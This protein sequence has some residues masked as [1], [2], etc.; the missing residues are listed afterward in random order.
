MVGPALGRRTNGTFSMGSRFRPLRP[1]TP[2]VLAL[3]ALLPL[4]ACGDLALGPAAGDVVM[5]A[6]V[7]GGAWSAGKLNAAAEASSGGVFAL[8]GAASDGRSIGIVLANIRGPGTY[9]LGVEPSVV[10]GVA[11]LAAGA[12][13]WATP[14]SGAAGS[15]TIDVLTPARIAGTFE[16]TGTLALG[17]SPTTTRRVTQ[18]TFDLELEAGGTLPGVPENAGSI[19]RMTLGGEPFNAASVVEEDL[20]GGIQFAAANLTHRV[21]VSL[22]GVA[23][24]GSYTL[25]LSAGRT[26]SVSGKVGGSADPYCCWGGAAAD[27]GMVTITSLTDARVRGTFSATLRP[28]P[29]SSQTQP[30]VLTSG[31]F[32]IGR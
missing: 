1:P 22:P 20:A 6:Q 17:S 2:L 13:V 31:T 3:P 7:D 25:D 32:D 24:T 27:A 28:V 14:M 4:V 11:E 21:V 8:Y 16:F 26:I 12:V 23:S 5:T 29:G 19:V 30:L 15:V 10:G 9:A 18:G